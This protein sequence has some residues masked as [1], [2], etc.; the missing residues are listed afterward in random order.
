MG[1]QESKLISERTSEHQFSIEDQTSKSPGSIKIISVS[2]AEDFKRLELDKLSFFDLPS[3]IK[4]GL[5]IAPPIL[6]DPAENVPYVKAVKENSKND[7]IK[8]YGQLNSKNQKHGCGIYYMV[9]K[10]QLWIG[11]FT[12]DAPENQIQI[13][14][15]DKS[16]FKGE[17]SRGELVDGSIQFSDGSSYRG[18]F[19]KGYPH[20]R[21]TK[22]NPDGSYITGNFIEGEP[23]GLGVSY[24]KDGVRYVGDIGNSSYH[25]AHLRQFNLISEISK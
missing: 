13:Y 9:R 23:K 20:G 8:Y 1:C 24:R 19:Q 17:T 15:A 25:S 21:G 11:K 10:Q 18:A 6:S 22:I 12:N 7:V 2:S 4:E 14:F 16:T 3:E 5:K